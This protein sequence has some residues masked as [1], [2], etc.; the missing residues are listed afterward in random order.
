MRR[1]ALQRDVHELHLHRRRSLRRHIRTASRAASHIRPRTSGLSQSAARQ[2][3]QQSCE[4]IGNLHFGSGEQDDTDICGLKG[5]AHVVRALLCTRAARNSFSGL[6]TVPR[7]ALLQCR[8]PAQRLAAT[9]TNLQQKIVA[10]NETVNFATR[11]DFYLIG[12][13]RQ[14]VQLKK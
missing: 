1:H 9:Q 3:R 13:I 4:S 7:D 8:V 10:S 14:R 5:R 12:S 2:R 6:P 11:S